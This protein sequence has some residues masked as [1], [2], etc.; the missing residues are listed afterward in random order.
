VVSTSVFSPRYWA[1][2]LLRLRLAARIVDLNGALPGTQSNQLL[3]LSHPVKGMNWVVAEVTFENTI[4]PFLVFDYDVDETITILRLQD[5][6]FLV[7]ATGR[8]YRL[9]PALFGKDG[10]FGANIR[11]PHSGSKVSGKLAFEVD[12]A[13][14]E[15]MELWLFDEN[16][17]AI[18]V[19]VVGAVKAPLPAGAVVQA[20]AAVSLAVGEHGPATIP[21][22]TARAGMQFYQ[23]DLWGRAEWTREVPAYFLKEGADAKE[24]AANG[25]FFEYMRSA[26]LLSIVTGD[27]YAAPLVPEYRGKDV[28]HPVFLPGVWTRTRLYYEVPASEARLELQALFARMGLSDTGAN[29]LDPLRFI[30]RE[31]GELPMQPVPQVELLDVKDTNELSISLA[32]VKDAAAWG[33][34]PISQIGL[35]ARFENTGAEAGMLKPLERF[36]LDFQGVQLIPDASGKQHPFSAPDQ[37]YLERGC[38]GPC[39]WCLIVRRQGG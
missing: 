17:A 33:L 12:G 2:F 24:K 26:E 14:M 28:L 37:L 10:H 31:G 5:R 9:N 19:P 32:L 29:V 18:R 8:A 39:C 7:G 1:L 4:D 23:V 22:R 21:G 13:D 25:F 38:Q 34:D 11:L 35:W 15:S 36:W 27:G 20:N 6:A 16:F 3:P 30:L